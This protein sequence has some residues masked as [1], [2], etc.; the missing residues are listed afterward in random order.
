M[1]KIAPHC[2]NV[3][4]LV[5]VLLQMMTMTMIIIIMIIMVTLITKMMMNMMILIMVMM[6]CLHVLDS[7][8]KGEEG[9]STGGRVKIP[10]PGF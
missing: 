6:I 3:Q 5:V 7:T 1:N 9:L 2:I 4:H 10:A 8:Y